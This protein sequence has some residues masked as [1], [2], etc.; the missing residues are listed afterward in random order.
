MTEP[1]IE[2]VIREAQEEGDRERGLGRVIQDIQWLQGLDV[3]P[4]REKAARVL[5]FQ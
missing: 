4:R 2:R 5:K 1:W 3:E